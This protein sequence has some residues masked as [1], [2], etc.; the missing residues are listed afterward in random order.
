[1]EEIKKKY[2]EHQSAGPDHEHDGAE[3]SPQA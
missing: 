2:A 3:N 1:M